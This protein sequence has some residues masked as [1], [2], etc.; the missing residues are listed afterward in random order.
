MVEPGGAALAHSA[1]LWLQD[2]GHDVARLQ[3]CHQKPHSDTLHALQRYRDI[4]AA[5]GECDK[6]DA[7]RR[8]GRKVTLVTKLSYV[9]LC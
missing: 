8:K 2:G 1:G 6:V 3:H 9:M 4:P 7:G 5:I